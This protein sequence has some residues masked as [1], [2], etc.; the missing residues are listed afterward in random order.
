MSDEKE[1]SPVRVADAESL[2]GPAVLHGDAH[3]VRQLKN[4]H[5]AMISIGGV[6]GTGWYSPSYACHLITPARGLF[7]GTATSLQNGGPVGLLLGYMTVGT[8]CYSVMVST[9]VVPPSL[10]LNSFSQVSLAE[11]VAFLPIKR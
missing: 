3:L 5:I 7:L 4:R 2:D 6:I 10:W 1:K 9:S 8:I 11:M